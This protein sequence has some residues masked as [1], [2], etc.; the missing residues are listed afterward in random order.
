MCEHCETISEPCFA[1][2]TKSGI[3]RPENISGQVNQDVQQRVPS[4]VCILPTAVRVEVLG[5][6]VTVSFTATEPRR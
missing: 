6:D 5:R 1:H 2:C 4:I 3:L